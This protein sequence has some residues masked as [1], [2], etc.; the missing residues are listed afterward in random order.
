MAAQAG[1]AARGRAAVSHGRDQG[2]VTPATVADHVE[3][4]GGDPEAFWSG[5]LQSLCAEHHDS[6]KQRDDRRG[7]TRPSLD[8]HGLVAESLWEKR[9]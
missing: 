9:K 3:P 5:A 2:K 6:V 8:E 1:G 7:N 4:H